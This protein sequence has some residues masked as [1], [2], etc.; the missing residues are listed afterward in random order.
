MNTRYVRGITGA[1]SL[2]LL[3]GW[4]GLR[5]E[6]AD[7]FRPYLRFHSGDVDPLW[8]VD[9]LWSFGLG[10]NFTRHLGAELAFD[11]FTRDWGEPVNIAEV[12]SYHLV[13]ELRLRYPLLNDRLVPYLITGIGP[14]WMQVKDN[15]PWALNQSIQVEGYTFAVTVGAGI[16]YFIADNVTFGLEGK[17]MWVD[18]IEGSVDGQPQEVDLSSPIFTFGLRVFFDENQPRPLVSAEPDPRSRFYFGVRV[19]G[20]LLTDD[21]LVSGVHLGPEQAAWGGAMS[22]TGGLLLGADFGQDWG[23][24]LSFDHVNHVLNVDGLGDAWEYGQGWILA[25]LRLRHPMGRWTPYALLGAGVCYSEFKDEK[26]GSVGVTAEG[27]RF[28]PAVGVGAGVE[29]FIVRN[30]SLN[31]D[32]RWGYSWDHQFEIPGYLGAQTGDMS[33]FAATLGFRVYLFDF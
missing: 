23:T 17:Y 7:R 33:Y 11:Y 1:V 22:Q 32:A 16:E 9:D 3:A 25:S 20:N 14:S 24:E 12:S 6:D 31:L 28:H 27:N 30:F 5:A 18:P 8:E 13:P 10:A 4:V 21:Q 2:V 19:G 29:Y 26:L 15:K